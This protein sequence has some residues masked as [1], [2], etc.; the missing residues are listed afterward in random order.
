[1]MSQNRQGDLDRRRS[2]DDCDIN[3][4]AELEI[5]IADLSAAVAR[6]TTMLEAHGEPA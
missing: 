4:E 2:V 1:M 3:R 6:L 5:G